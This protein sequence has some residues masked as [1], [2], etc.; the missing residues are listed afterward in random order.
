MKTAAVAFSSLEASISCDHP[1]KL[2]FKAAGD[3][4]Y[5]CIRL[6]TIPTL[7]WANE[8]SAWLTAAYRQLW[9][10]QNAVW[11]S[12][13]LRSIKNTRVF[14]HFWRRVGGSTLI[15]SQSGPEEDRPGSSE[16]TW[17]VFPSQGKSSGHSIPRCG[18]GAE[19][20]QTSLIALQ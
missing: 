5:N 20:T 1:V 7:V 2:W 8:C 10:I 6:F 17:S 18:S 19:L 4:K 9:L 15:S 13:L 14:G 3:G 11:M 16:S 12:N